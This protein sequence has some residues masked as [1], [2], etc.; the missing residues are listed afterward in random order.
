MLNDMIYLVNLQ[1]SY[2]YKDLQ[3]TNQISILDPKISNFRHFRVLQIYKSRKFPP[4]IFSTHV[5]GAGV[6]L[7]I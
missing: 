6:R 5:I 1:V 7:T 4:T 2:P 3:S